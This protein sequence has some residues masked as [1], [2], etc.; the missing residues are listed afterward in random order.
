MRDSQ[1]RTIWARATG[2]ISRAR[3]VRRAA[4]EGLEDR[5]LFAAT[6]PII[7]EFLAIND[8]GIQDEDSNRSDWIELHNPTASDVNLDGYYLTDDA[9]LLTK[10][11]F[12]SV[13]IPSGGYT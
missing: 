2:R 6:T 4:I 9:A 7:S 1:Q 11:R 10:W 13:T 3:A 5:R 8:T 12:P